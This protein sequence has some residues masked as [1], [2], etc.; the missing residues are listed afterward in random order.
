[1]C[2][3]NIKNW[4]VLNLDFLLQKKKKIFFLVR[5][6]TE[7]MREFGALSFGVCL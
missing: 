5:V 3:K 7:N 4:Y 1:M 6:N 2:K